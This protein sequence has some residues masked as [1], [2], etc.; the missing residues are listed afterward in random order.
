MFLKLPFA[1][2][3][4]TWRQAIATTDK[5]KQRPGIAEVAAAAKVSTATVDR[6][7]NNRG[8]VREATVQR[9]IEAAVELGYVH[10][11]QLTSSKE[12]APLKLVFLLPGGTNPYLRNL[13]ELIR[14]GDCVPPRLQVRCASHFVKG[15]DPQAL[16]DGIHEYSGKVDGIAMMGLEHP[17]VREAIN[18]ATRKGTQI[19]TI[20]TDVSRCERAAYVGLDNRAVGRT[21]AFLLGRFCGQKEGEVGMI[22]GSFSYL[23]HNERE[24]GFL[25]LMQESFP[26]LHIIGVREGHDDFVENYQLTRSLLEQ[27]PGLVGIYNIG[28]SSGGVAT[29]L[30][31]AG[32][33]QDIVFIGHGLSDDTRS[34]L[35]DGTI[36][37][38]ISQAPTTI[39]HN[40]CQIFSNI[41]NG[42]APM[43]R[44]L[45][46]AM[47]VVCRENLP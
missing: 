6:V 39:I 40:V 8:G 5:N 14:S 11:G 15:F 13:S 30:R 32:K 45:E 2:D 33:T 23:A 37:V 26:H 24:M 29:A 21:A 46:L 17:V 9:V 42:L 31:E 3:L 27:H 38:V 44:I 7:L 35:I 36:D 43:E 18:E 12:S 4:H 34:M 22:A 16:A 1:L 28:G 47:R 10:E 25:S 41:K 19:T 20:I